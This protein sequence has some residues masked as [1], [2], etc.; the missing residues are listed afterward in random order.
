MAGKPDMAHRLP[1]GEPWTKCSQSQQ[2]KSCAMHVMCMTHE[3]KR[4]HSCLLGNDQYSIV[5][6][7]TR[8]LL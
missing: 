5:W 7:E 4:A 6:I 8:G 3:H 1:F 2:T